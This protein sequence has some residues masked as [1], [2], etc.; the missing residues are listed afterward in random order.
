ML[1][2]PLDADTKGM[3][4]KL[5]PLCKSVFADGG[6]GKLRAGEIY[7]LMVQAVDNGGFL[8]ENIPQPGIG[9]KADLMAASVFGGKVGMFACLQ[10][11]DI[12]MERTA[13][14]YV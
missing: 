7:C 12:L 5:K 9:M 8:P 11:P 4:G 13:K 1:G 2:M 14:K 3:G 10:V 6:N